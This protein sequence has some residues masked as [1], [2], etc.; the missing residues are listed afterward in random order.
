MNSP[1]TL[2]EAME[3]LHGKKHDL[4]PKDRHFFFL[5]HHIA[6][7]HEL[8]IPE[9]FLLC[10]INSLDNDDHCYATNQYFADILGVDERHVRRLIHRLIKLKKIETKGKYKNR[11]IIK[12]LSHKKI[13]KNE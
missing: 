12:S 9:R 7:D 4:D 11:R 10:M 1:D 13:W 2:K 6:N 8:S 5:P 3:I